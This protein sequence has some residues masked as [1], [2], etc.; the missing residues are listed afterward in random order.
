[1]AK[2]YD[3]ARAGAVVVCLVPVR[4]D[5]TWWQRFMPL[6][7]VTFL[8]GE[9]MPAGF[10]FTIVPPAKPLGRRTGEKPGTNKRSKKKTGVATRRP[11]TQP[12]RGA[13]AEE[14]G[15]SIVSNRRLRRP[16]AT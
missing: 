16:G 6:G 14:E 11:S 1:M 10:R 7:E 13:G 15:E 8:A 9:R 4:T 2:A 3:S 5:T 12:V